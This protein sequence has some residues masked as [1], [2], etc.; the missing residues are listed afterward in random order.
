MNLQTHDL[1]VEGAGLGARL[2]HE[3]TRRAGYGRLAAALVVVREVGI[4]VEDFFRDD[5]G[6]GA[7]GVEA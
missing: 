1:D 7:F 5:G 4:D 3:V 2:V 6:A